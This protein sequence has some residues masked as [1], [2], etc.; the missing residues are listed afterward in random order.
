MV[1]MQWLSNRSLPVDHQLL[2]QMKTFCEMAIRLKSS[3]T[4]S[5]KARDLL[6]LIENRVHALHLVANVS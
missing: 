4:M 2:W 6:S 5:D 3:T 1:I